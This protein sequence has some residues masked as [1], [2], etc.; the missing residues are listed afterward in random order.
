MDDSSSNGGGINLGCA[1]TGLVA[2]GLAILL[3][4]SLRT[5]SNEDEGCL[6]P[7]LGFRL[8]GLPAYAVGVSCL[9]AAF[10][11]TAR[12]G[13]DRLLMLAVLGGLSLFGLWGLFRLAQ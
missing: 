12:T 2:L 9:I 1:L 4:F 13:E 7:W 6:F 5:C 10:W 3:A 11:R 8:Y